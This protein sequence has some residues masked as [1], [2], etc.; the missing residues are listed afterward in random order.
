MA[1]LE[2]R[3]FFGTCDA[4]SRQF[5]M[6]P[7]KQGAQDTLTRHLLADCDGKASQFAWSLNGPRV[8]SDSPEAVEEALQWVRATQR[9][10]GPNN[11]D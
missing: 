11:G 3:E 2:Q 5:G 9:M 7:T 8:L 1:I 6:N 10:G 4:C